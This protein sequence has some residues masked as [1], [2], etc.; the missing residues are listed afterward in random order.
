MQNRSYSSWWAIFCLSSDWIFRELRKNSLQQDLSLSSKVIWA[1]I[2]PIDQGR[3]LQIFPNEPLLTWWCCFRKFSP[4][5]WFF[6]EDIFWLL[7]NSHPCIWL[8]WC[9]DLKLPLGFCRV[10]IQ[11]WL[12]DRLDES[13]HLSCSLSWQ[14]LS[15]RSYRLPY[16]TNQW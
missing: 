11:E 3:V 16:G 7:A 4:N 5:E 2:W 12:R 10:R 13:L 8:Y 14:F 1:L 15:R 6:D 9:W